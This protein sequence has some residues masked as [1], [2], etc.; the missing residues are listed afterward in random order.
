M[1]GHIVGRASAFKHSDLRE[2]ERLIGDGPVHLLVTGSAVVDEV[3]EVAV[4]AATSAAG[5]GTDG[6]EAPEEGTPGS[7]SSPTL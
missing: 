5:V 6:R 7:R 3:V 2:A 4:K 1:V